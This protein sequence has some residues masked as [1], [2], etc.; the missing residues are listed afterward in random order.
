MQPEIFEEIRQAESTNWWFVGR[1]QLILDFYVRFEEARRGRH[2]RPKLLDMG[3]GTGAVLESLSSHAQVFGADISDIAL[4]LC[5]NRGQRRVACANG[6]HLSFANGAFDYIVS[7]DV[8]EHIENDLAVMRELHRVC[9][10]GGVVLITIPACE[11][12]RTTRDDRLMHKRRYHRAQFVALARAAGFEVTK[13]SYYCAFFFPAI[14]A[15]VLFNRLLGRK[16]DIKQDVVQP[17]GWINALL[18]ELLFLE[19]RLLR[20][21]NLPF[22][23]SLFCVLHKSPLTRPASRD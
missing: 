4:R 15:V 9:R 16:P 17:A 10:E 7:L 2:R 1:R 12:L 14:A 5:V 11:W 13:C 6:T 8:V 21:V 3:C 23:V 20:T 19:Q 22:G 18:R